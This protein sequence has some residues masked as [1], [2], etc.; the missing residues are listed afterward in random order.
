MEYKLVSRCV[1]D[2]YTLREMYTESNPCTLRELCSG[3]WMPTHQ[4]F[5][6]L[7]GEGHGRVEAEYRILGQPHDVRP[8]LRI[9]RQIEGTDFLGTL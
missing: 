8:E 1:G 2:P 9:Q 3:L 5:G 4:L 6:K 7:D